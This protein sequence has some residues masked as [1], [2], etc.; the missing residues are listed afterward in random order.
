MVSFWRF[1]GRACFDA[2]F[3]KEFEKLNRKDPDGKEGLDIQA[4]WDMAIATGLHPS[5]FETWEIARLISSKTILRSMEAIGSAIPKEYQPGFTLNELFELMGVLCFDKK[6][7]EQM[8]VPAAAGRKVEV[9]AL[10]ASYNVLL[11]DRE[12]EAFLT[13]I[14]QPKTLDAIGFISAEAW[15]EPCDQARAF[16]KEYGTH[17]WYGDAFDE[18]FLYR[19]KLE[20]FRKKAHELYV[21]TMTGREE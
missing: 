4:L 3:R 19:P 21:K 10:L 9:R 18:G 8:H 13:V 1:I 17:H 2:S 15:D 16:S 7:A 11:S 12:L 5:L 20:P 14:K 6:F